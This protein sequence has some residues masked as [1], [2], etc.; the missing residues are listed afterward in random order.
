MKELHRENPSC[1]LCI[2]LLN[3]RTPN[4]TIDCL[5]SLVAQAG[6]LGAEIVVVDNCSPDSSVEVISSWISKSLYSDHI[7]LVCST[8]NGGF[9]SGNNIGIEYIL[10]EYYLLLNS[11]TILREDSLKTMLSAIASDDSIGLLSPRLEWPDGTPQESCFRY[12]RPLGQ[13]LSSSN[14]GLFFRLFPKLEVAHRV[15]KKPA[16]YEWTSFACV[17]IRRKVFLDI[18]LLDEKF[19][20]YFED[21]EFCWRACQSGWRVRNEPVARV[22]HLR[23]GS[24]PVKSNL[25]ER[26]R[27]A[28]Y[29]YESRTRYFYLLFGRVGLLLANLCWTFGWLVALCRAAI[30]PSFQMPTCKREWQD[31]WINFFHPKKQFT[32]PSKYK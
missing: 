4:L 13:I 6:E 14:T 18:G 21:V 10:A 17:M 7:H 24:S 26:K 8:K 19:F 3:Y 11:D 30:Q 28:R 20:M 15:T 27:Q 22:V 23:G 32:H 12:H 2:V 5:E 25:I 9:A 16:D 1:E 29:Y 31:I